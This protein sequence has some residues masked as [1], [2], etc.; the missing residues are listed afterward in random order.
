[1]KVSSNHHCLFIVFVVYRMG[2]KRRITS[3]ELDTLVAYFTDWI[4]YYF[5][6]FVLIN[7]NL[8]QFLYQPYGFFHKFCA[9]NNVKLVRDIAQFHVY[10][11]ELVDPHVAGLIVL[12]LVLLSNTFPDYVLADGIQ[13][14]ETIL[15]QHQVILHIT[16]Q[17][18]EMPQVLYFCIWNG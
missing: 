15:I 5:G 10:S 9:H 18:P 13:L 12:C 2:G 1:M 16:K 11:A 7:F 14:C 6:P 8:L 3:F 17:T 4:T